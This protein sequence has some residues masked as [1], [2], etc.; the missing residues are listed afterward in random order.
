LPPVKFLVL[1][2]RAGVGGGSALGICGFPA[3]PLTVGVVTGLVAAGRE[4][5]DGRQRAGRRGG[6]GWVVKCA[7][8][9]CAG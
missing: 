5:G 7:G 6:V 9:C 4:L 2:S 1:W 3:L 8:R